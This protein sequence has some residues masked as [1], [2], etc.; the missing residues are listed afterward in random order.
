MGFLACA[1]ALPEAVE[2]FAHAQASVDVQVPSDVLESAIRVKPRGADDPAA[3]ATARARPSSV[4]GDGSGDGGDGAGAAADAAPV[5]A[6]VLARCGVGACASIL[7]LRHGYALAGQDTLPADL[8]GC[9]L[10]LVASLSTTPAGRRL[11]AGVAVEGD[12][13]SPILMSDGT[14]VPSV[15][16]RCPDFLDAGL[17]MAIIA[18]D[19]QLGQELVAAKRALT[20]ATVAASVAPASPEG[21]DAEAA[22]SETTRAPRSGLEVLVWLLDRASVAMATVDASR[23]SSSSLRGL[24][25]T[26]TAAL[27]GIL[28]TSAPAFIAFLQTPPL[29]SVRA[30]VRR[31]SRQ[32]PGSSG[33]P[34]AAAP[35]ADASLP[36][37]FQT[38]RGSSFVLLLLRAL[39]IMM[40]VQPPRKAG[41]VAIAP[42]ASSSSISSPLSADAAEEAAARQRRLRQDRYL[43][44]TMLCVLCAADEPATAAA[45]NAAPRPTQAIE[46][47]TFMSL[48]TSLT[49]RAVVQRAFAVLIPWA[50][51][52]ELSTSQP[53]PRPAPPP[54]PAD[55]P[56][57]SPLGKSLLG[58]LGSA[59]GPG[60]ASA[61]RRVGTSAALSQPL[62]SKRSV[63]P[64]TASP[65]TPAGASTAEPLSTWQVAVGPLLGHAFARFAAA[66]SAR[67]A[68]EAADAVS[69]AAVAAQQA[70]SAA[71]VEEAAPTAAAPAPLPAVSLR[72]GGGLTPFR[73][74][75]AQHIARASLTSPPPPPA[76]SVPVVPPEALALL[77]C[78]L[79][80]S[81]SMEVSIAR[82]GWMAFAGLCGHP[83]IRG[84]ILRSR[85]L[86]EGVEAPPAPAVV[87]SL[88]TGAS[89]KAA[90]AAAAAAAEAAAQPP[91]MIPPPYQP[92]LEWMDSHVQLI[93]IPPPPPPSLK[94][95]KPAADAADAALNG[96]A[97]HTHRSARR[98]SDGA[99]VAAA[100]AAGDAEAAAP[101]PPPPPPPEPPSLE[102]Q[103]TL[104]AVASA[105]HEIVATASLI[106][107]PRKA[108]PP[109]PP[110]AVV[111]ETAAAA[112]AAAL[113]A[114]ASGAPLPPPA[115]PPEPEVFCRADLWRGGVPVMLYHVV[116]CL[117]RLLPAAREG[118]ADH[119]SA[120]AAA[121]PGAHATARG[122]GGAAAALSLPPEAIGALR[123]CAAICNHFAE[124]DAVAR[125]VAG[126][127]NGDSDASRSLCPTAGGTES[128]LRAVLSATLSW[129][130]SVPDVPT[131]AYA[132]AAS[133]SLSRV[134][135]FG[136]ALLAA[137]ILQRALQWSS[138][139]LK[140]YRKDNAHL[141]LSLPP[142]GPPSADGNANGEE[143]EEAGGEPEPCRDAYAA[144]SF[145][146]ASAGAAGASSA[147]S[148]HLFTD[149]I[150]P[151]LFVTGASPRRIV[152][153]AAPR[154]SLLWLHK[155]LVGVL[156]MLSCNPAAAIALSGGGHPDLDLRATLQVCL[157]VRAHRELESSR[158]RLFPI[159]P[160]TGCGSTP[161]PL[162]EQGA[163]PAIAAAAPLP[164]GCR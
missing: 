138:C 140:W 145:Y 147:P 11:M 12:A 125:P 79:C 10:R 19:A 67:C 148:L 26:A 117:C 49:L 158:S 84:L 16:L 53:I 161:R 121:A 126:D 60:M 90:A 102:D 118:A 163:V 160:L 114:G 164:G 94:P 154:M 96:E 59:F 87:I 80:L 109:P 83:A 112:S 62:P 107:V 34:S 54:A 81:S 5:K 44:S 51:G 33:G 21:G 105:L 159:A 39:P 9:C 14:A 41:G 18:A 7:V 133:W 70:A 116:T 120:V 65:V 13:D 157:E 100:P 69:A 73:A 29:A 149:A 77:Q 64:P 55:A 93:A 35:S 75:R 155:T 139:L 91:P 110:A 46:A 85:G 89:R 127:G 134:P 38:E 122:G 162:D 106:A 95:A 129:L 45:A 98:V 57:A 141:G 40:H 128:Q 131:V 58:T 52:V 86:T 31:G 88:P 132:V 101:P 146:A 27:S 71:A 43:L 103:R 111:A 144:V 22:G 63:V 1:A 97:A 23:T 142:N 37:C 143:E 4:S 48:L 92:L 61:M 115:P 156:W 8:E 56:P 66:L 137:G 153:A 24:A 136:A 99:S 6:T 130:L 68:K 150:A 32:Q 123:Y 25:G 30:Q 78:S 15:P 74:A 151:A 82:S 36:A 72:G 20:H 152:G 17:A 3:G 42:S 50:T 76:P 135:D 119:G 113:A 104:R 47:G 28:T 2:A 108:P 124:C